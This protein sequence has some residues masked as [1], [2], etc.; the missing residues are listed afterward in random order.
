MAYQKSI[1]PLYEITG[2]VI[3]VTG[4]CG[5]IGRSMTKAFHDRGA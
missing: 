2:R 1:D 4:A 5:L 3:V